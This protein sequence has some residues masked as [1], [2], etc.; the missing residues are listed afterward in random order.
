MKKI[1]TLLKNFEEGGETTEILKE[2]LNSGAAPES[3]AQDIID[4]IIEHPTGKTLHSSKNY[5]TFNILLPKQ[6]FSSL[7][8]N[9]KNCSNYSL[10]SYCSFKYPTQPDDNKKRLEFE[11]RI[12]K[13]KIE[14]K[15]RIEESK[16]RK[17]PN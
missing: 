17:S 14:M 13:S 10:K 8:L 7:F 15:K 11:K 6:N 1:E 12:E 4:K 3:I 16:R 2:L 5:L 9:P